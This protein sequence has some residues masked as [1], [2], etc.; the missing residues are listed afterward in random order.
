LALIYSVV[1]H[2]TI[3]QSQTPVHLLYERKPGPTGYQDKMFSNDQ[4]LHLQN[5]KGIQYHTVLKFETNKII[6]T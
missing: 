3:F 2:T 4:F 5:D 1:H 6:R